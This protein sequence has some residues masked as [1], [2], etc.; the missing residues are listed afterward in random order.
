MSK[1]ERKRIIGYI[2]RHPDT[3]ED[4]RQQFERWMLAREQESEIDEILWEIWNTHT[5]PVSE[6]EDRKGL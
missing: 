6:E 1:T 2:F 4:I 3:P 5:A